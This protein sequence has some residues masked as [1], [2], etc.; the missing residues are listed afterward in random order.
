MSKLVNIGVVADDGKYYK[1]YQSSIFSVK[2]ICHTTFF[3][4]IYTIL[5]LNR[6]A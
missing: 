2:L 1:I 4:R 3:L 6:C 5:K